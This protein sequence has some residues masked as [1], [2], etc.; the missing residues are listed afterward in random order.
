MGNSFACQ[1]ASGKPG[2]CV[3]SSDCPRGP[4]TPCRTQGFVGDSVCCPSESRHKRAASDFP[5]DP[6]LAVL[7]ENRQLCGRSPPT[8]RDSGSPDF[9]AEYVLGGKGV[10]DQK[11]YPFVVAIFRD[12]VS[13]E[14]FWCGGALITR[15]LVLSAA[16]CFHK[17]K[18]TQ[19]LVRIGSLD[20]SPGR[21]K[22][23]S[24]IPM[25]RKVETVLMHP[26]YNG[27]QQNADLALLVLDSEAQ[28]KA[29]LRPAACLPLEGAE[30][31][32][33]T[34]VILGWGHNA[35]G[36]KLQRLLQE[37]DV[38]LVDNKACDDRYRSLSGYK[39]VFRSGVDQDF[40]CAGN[41]TQGGV[42]ACQHDSGGPLAVRASRDGKSVWELAGVV[43]FGV[44]CGTPSYPGV[45]SRVASFVPWILRTSAHL[46]NVND[47]V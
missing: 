6:V 5:H 38:P 31:D 41:L 13:V 9:P 18:N 12:E 46:T 39:T 45:Y 36:G 10:N 11:R 4:H 30:P 17:M 47:V 3:S 37:A 25:E 44:Q 34:G 2:R 19:F 42:D 7:R 14:N 27:R 24:G 15:R 28:L 21:G 40:L 32:T 20:I 16:H 33:D 23:S 35:F 26:S 22:P 8:K 43:S 1:T 29:S